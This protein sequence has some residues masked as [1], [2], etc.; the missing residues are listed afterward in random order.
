ME[1]I[2]ATP[3]KKEDKWN[4]WGWSSSFRASIL[5]RSRM[6][7]IKVSRWEPHWWMMP[8]PSCC[9]DV[10][11]RSRCKISAYPKIPLRGVRSSWLILAK[12]SLLAE[13][14]VSAS[15]L[16]SCSSRV[17]SLTLASRVW[18]YSLRRSLASSSWRLVSSSW[19]LVAASRAFA[20]L[21]C[22]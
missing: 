17:R 15:F 7:L 21:S 4:S 20:R 22:Q 14:A 9:L 2:C 13:L 8:S 19:R 1:Q 12:N 11:F 16:A 5:E 6:S 3:F 18:E 10:V